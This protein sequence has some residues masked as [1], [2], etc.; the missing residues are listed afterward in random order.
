[1]I[2]LILKLLYLSKCTTKACNV[3]YNHLFFF[4]T[5]EWRSQLAILKEIYRCFWGFFKPFGWFPNIKSSKK[6]FLNNNLERFTFYFQNK[7]KKSL[8]KCICIYNY[9]KQFFKRF[10]FVSVITN[11]LKCVETIFQK[12]FPLNSFG[13]IH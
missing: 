11:N 9:W 1:M 3:S 4:V 7:L 5:W 8:E 13:F 10:N 6:S 12:Y 2:L